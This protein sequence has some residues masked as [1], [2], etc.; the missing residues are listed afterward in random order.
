MPTMTGS[1]AQVQ[2]EAPERAPNAGPAGA[3]LRWAVVGGG[4]LGLTLAL[5]LNQAGQ[6]VTVFEAADD[7]GGLASAWR[8]GD[9]TWDRY[10]H[11]IMRSDTRLRALLTELDLEQEIH[12]AVTRT[13]FYTGRAMHPLNNVIDY[14]RLPVLGPVDK[15][16]LAATILYASR[17]EN[18]RPLENLSAADW[19]TRLSG[20]RTYRNLWQPL[21][22][23]KLGSNEGKASAAYIWS[24]IR[25]FY[26][27]RQGGMQREMFGYVP[28]ENIYE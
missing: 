27:A 2:A 4:M 15:A 19:L 5:R 16:R 22:R 1:R 14:L 6:H 17:I 23:S 11:V 8:V 7:F 3:P 26:G 10:Y 20:A 25:R 18:G 9:V 28:G 12:W 13:N 21:L 24:V